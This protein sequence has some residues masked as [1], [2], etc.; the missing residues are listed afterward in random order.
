MKCRNFVTPPFD[1]LF[2]I[3]LE[4]RAT[5]LISPNINMFQLIIGREWRVATD[6]TGTPARVL[7]AR[8]KS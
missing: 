5:V 8:Q 3:V 7:I 6:C 2:I 4:V 1:K